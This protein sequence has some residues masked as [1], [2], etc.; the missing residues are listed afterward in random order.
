[1]AFQTFSAN[2]IDK[3]A[4]GHAFAWPKWLEKQAWDIEQ[5]LARHKADLI[6]L[7]GTI[8]VLAGGPPCQGFSFA[9]RRFE[10][11]PRNLL[12]EKYVEVV[13]ALQPQAL[14]LENVP[15][16]KVAHARR[17]VV[18]LPVPGVPVEKLKS[19]YN[20]LVD[21]LDVAGYKM[22]AMLV[23][24]S[25]FGVPQRRSRLIAVGIRKDLCEWLERFSISLHRSRRRR[26]SWRTPEAS[27][28]R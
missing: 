26:S 17:N 19:F 5:V 15:G 1:M 23:D 11:D 2:F 21:S 4:P 12:F 16:M 24:S 8:D 18:E 6:G 7:R 20:K 3:P 9:G 22:E 14:I 25:R 28:G 10:E 27:R 13:E